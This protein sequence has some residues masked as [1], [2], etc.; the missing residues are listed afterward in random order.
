MKVGEESVRSPVVVA[1]GVLEVVLEVVLTLVMLS[2]VETEKR[3][4]R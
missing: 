3:K 2:S 4:R 1:G